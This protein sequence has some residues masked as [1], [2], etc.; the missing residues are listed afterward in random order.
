VVVEFDGHL[1]EWKGAQDVILWVEEE[2]DA[3]GAQ[4]QAYLLEEG[5]VL[6]SVE[7]RVECG[8]ALSY[9]GH[10][11]SPRVVKLKHFAD[12]LLAFQQS[13]ASLAEGHR[14][15]PVTLNVLFGHSTPAS[16]A[17]AHDELCNY[18]RLK[19]AV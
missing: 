19:N 16:F 1:I 15:W 14:A 7:L 8:V 5:N 17:I 13:R 2:Q 4:I 6:V 3:I 18:R 9:V 12:H 10:G 11:A